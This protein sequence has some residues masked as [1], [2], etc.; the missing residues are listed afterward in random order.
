MAINKY[1]VVESGNVALGQ[2]GS[3]LEV[4]T[5]SVSGSFVAFTTLSDTKFTSL[6]PASSSYIGTSGGSGDALLNTQVL[7]SGITIFGRWTEFTLA[8]GQIIAY[9]G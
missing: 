7:P 1:S 3:V 8:E 2:V 4:G 6:T 9:T 5:S